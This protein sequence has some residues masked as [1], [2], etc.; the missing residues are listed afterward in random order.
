M[1]K[2]NF[3]KLLNELKNEEDIFRENDVN[4]DYIRPSSMWNKPEKESP[5]YFIPENTESEKMSK[6]N[7]IWS[8]NKESLLLFLL[9]SVIV[10]V[11][12][13]ISSVNFL[14]VIGSISFLVFTALIFI[15]F[16]RYVS[17]AVSRTRVP[18]EIINR[19]ESIERRIDFLSK[20]DG[21]SSNT[22]PEKRL[23]RLEEEIQEMRMVLKTITAQY[24]R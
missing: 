16:F 11:L 1:K 24:R 3:E 14:T 21:I 13:L 9:A 4:F 15:T 8:E 22:L 17:S 6:F 20:K 23:S 2:N 19:I 5:K 12:G 10:I 18:D 7:V